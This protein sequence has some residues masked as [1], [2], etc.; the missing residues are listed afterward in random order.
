MSRVSLVSLVAL[1]MMAGCSQPAGDATTS[2]EEPPPSPTI[3][4]AAEQGEPLVLFL[5]LS[6]LPPASSPDGRAYE[7]NIQVSEVAEPALG[8]VALFRTSNGV[9][10]FESASVID[11]AAVLSEKW[12]SW[13]SDVD[14]ALF[15]FISDHPT[16]RSIR[17]AASMGRVT[18]ERLLTSTIGSIAAF[19]PFSLN[20]PVVEHGVSRTE[21]RG[22]PP[23]S[24]VRS[25]EEIRPLDEPQEGEW[26]SL[27]CV[28]GFTN[29]AALRETTLEHANG[30]ETFTGQTT[31]LR[32]HLAAYFGR[33]SAPV[34][35]EHRSD[36]YGSGETTFLQVFLQERPEWALTFATQDS[37]KEGENFGTQAGCL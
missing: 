23:L 17:V 16:P 21:A 37:R 13:P 24:T 2:G 20:G 28:T 19:G 14:G 12:G 10:T 36:S 11:H 27:T 4:Y 31:P 29:G 18:D 8:L 5:G 15:L 9:A 7:F 32:G 30:V 33:L 34:R 1:L 26:L 3:A 22:G 25:V 6:D 35:V